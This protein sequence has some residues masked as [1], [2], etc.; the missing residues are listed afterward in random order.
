MPWRVAYF[1]ALSGPN[2]CSSVQSLG[3]PTLE[4]VAIGVI[5]ARFTTASQLY[6][7]VD[8][9]FHIQVTA[10]SATLGL[11]FSRTNELSRGCCMFFHRQ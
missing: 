1:A 2:P 8:K 3:E 5:F 6:E 10:L 4:I 9:C 7:E 11:S